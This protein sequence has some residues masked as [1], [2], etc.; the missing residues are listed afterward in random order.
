MI[1]LVV[2]FGIFLFLSSEQNLMIKDITAI[3]KHDQ[4]KT[5]T[6]T[7][8]LCERSVVSGRMSPTKQDKT[9]PGR[10]FGRGRCQP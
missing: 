8:N 4:S 5:T 6:I 9:Q 3:S 1:V 2:F 10:I 7:T